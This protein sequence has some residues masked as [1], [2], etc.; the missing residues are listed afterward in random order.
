MG[1]MRLESY[2]KVDLQSTIAEFSSCRNR[3]WDE[4]V[5][6]RS[7]DGKFTIQCDY[8]RSSFV[9]GTESLVRCNYIGDDRKCSFCPLQRTKRIWV[10]VLTERREEPRFVSNRRKFF[11]WRKE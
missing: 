10:P 11:G 8:F 5:I 9:S 7:R 6:L 2:F 1:Q 4:F 3:V